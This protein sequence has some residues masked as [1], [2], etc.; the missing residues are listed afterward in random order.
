MLATIV[1]QNN[2]I[3]SWMRQQNE[4]NT[5]NLKNTDLELPVQFPL[6]QEDELK[7]LETHLENDNNLTE[8]V[9]YQFK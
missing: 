2:Q 1:E 3:L 8:L 7:S 9:C 4:F 6:H 5:N